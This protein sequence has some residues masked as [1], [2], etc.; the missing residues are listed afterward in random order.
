MTTKTPVPEP[1][2][3]ASMT[4]FG[5]AYFLDEADAITFGKMVSERGDTFNGG[6]YH[7]MSCGRSKGYDFNVKA[8]DPKVAGK[9][10][11]EG[12]GEGLVT[13]YAVTTA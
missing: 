5:L 7:G 10:P 6:F 8:T 13:L 3:T 11:V 2:Y 4:C 1:D 12:D 9:V